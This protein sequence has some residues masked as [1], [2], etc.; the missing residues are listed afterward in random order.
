VIDAHHVPAGLQNLLM[1][2]VGN[3]WPTGDETALRAEV[4][5]WRAAAESLRA[6]CHQLITTQCL[7]EQGLQG[8]TRSAFDD[9]MTGLVGSGPEDM[10]AVLPAL[11]ACCDSA[12]DALEDLANEI[13][14]LRVTIIGTLTVLWI[15]LM[16]DTAMLAFGGEAVAAAQLAATREFL[17]LALQRSIIIVVTRVGESVLAQLGFTLL[18]QLI[19]LAQRH[20]RALNPTQLRTAAVNGAIGGAVGAGAGFTGGALRAGAGRLANTRLTS[21]V[22]Q[23]AG[24]RHL[25]P[26]A[27]KASSGLIWAGGYAAVTGM[28]EGAAQDAA[29]GLS[30]DWVSGAANGAF[31]GVW[32]TR[33][34]TMNPANARSIS[35]ADHLEAH[36]NRYLRPPTPQPPA[37]VHDD[38]QFPDA[39]DS[40]DDEQFHDAQDSFDDEQ[41]R[42]SWLARLAFAS[43]GPNS[44]QAESQNG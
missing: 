8:T 11:T 4:G 23:W 29:L 16:I 33:H 14:T 27:A 21:P 17:L 25:L 34:T 24:N 30:G 40:F 31:D 5:A 6:C 15:Q 18:A 13:E 10:S 9:Y 35:P 22:Q 20:R 12:A 2:L 3:T 36:L 39:P 28:A 37:P 43:H 44:P 7:V 1:I 38:E 41:H 26:D 42:Q 32:G 19:E